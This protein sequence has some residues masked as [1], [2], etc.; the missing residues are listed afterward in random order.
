MNIVHYCRYFTMKLRLKSVLERL[1]LKRY[2]EC[3]SQHVKWTSGARVMMFCCLTMLD[4]SVDRSLGR[5]VG[6][7]VARSVGQSVM[8]RFRVGETPFLVLVVRSRL[9]SKLG[10]VFRVAVLLALG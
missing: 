9:G 2:A 4:H 7:S 6:R 8:V 10:F 3:T 5:S 1:V